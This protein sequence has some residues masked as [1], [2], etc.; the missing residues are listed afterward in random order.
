MPKKISLSPEQTSS[1][2]I[3]I[4]AKKGSATELARAQA[5]RMHEKKADPEFIEEMTG[6]QRSAIYNWRAKF[7]RKGISGLLDR[8]KAAPRALLKRNQIQQILHVLKNKSPRDFGYDA[9]FWTTTILAHLIK[10]QYNVQY[11]TKKTLYL[12]FKKAKFT[13]HKP[14]KQ[15]RNRNQ[16]AID[17]WIKK[18]TPKVKKYFKEKN[19]VVLTGDEMI[20]STQTTFQKIWLPANSFP[21]IDVSNK[22]ANRSVYGFLN[23]KNGVQYAFKKL[24]Q[25]SAITIE[26]LESLCKLYKGQKIVL[27]WDSAPWHR[28]KD[29]KKWLKKNRGKIRLEAFP[30][31]APELNPQEHVWKE[32]RSKVTHN[33]FIPD[34]DKSTDELVD[35]LN[36]TLFKYTL[37]GMP[38]SPRSRE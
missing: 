21:K 3:F 38:V 1:L 31:Y 12:L 36:N 19:T 35:Y 8:K 2:K 14:G 30:Y 9:D 15:Y 24:R 22:R 29:V 10:E 6:L 23:I 33:E 25:N 37:L 32:G 7:I 5:I 17:E 34:I 16:T 13:Y 4:K 27:Y 20:L 18:H 26:V 28:S 11:K